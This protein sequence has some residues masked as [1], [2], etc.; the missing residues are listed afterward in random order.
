[1]KTFVWFFTPAFSRRAQVILLA[2]FLVRC[3][4][5]AQ[6]HDDHDHTEEAENHAAHVQ[7]GRDEHGGPIVL[8]AQD[9]EDFGIRL[10]TADAGLIRQELRLPGEIRMNENAMAHVSP[11]FDGVV[12][13]I[14]HRL[15]DQVKTDDVL[16]EIESNDT[17]RPLE[18]KAPIDGTIVAF[19]ITPG[20]IISTDEYAYVIADTSSVWADLRVYQRDLPKVHD[21]QKVRL[22]AGHDYP[23]EEGSIAYVGPVVDETSRTGFIRVVVENPHGLFRPGL[24]VV[25]DVALDEFRL[26]IVVPRSAVHTLEDKSVVFVESENGDGFEASPVRLGKGD[27]ANVEILEGLAKGQRYVAEGGFFL[28]ADSQKENFGDGHAH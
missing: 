7:E 9:I 3:S 21:G 19:H 5:S 13:R 6:P 22:S 14:H 25:G 12:K 18:L 24:F 10:D 28:K 20:E 2:F 23:T 8:Q 16:A 17:F 15:G 4:A 27:S 26:P 11:R 1:M